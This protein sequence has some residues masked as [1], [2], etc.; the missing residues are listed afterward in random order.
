M[1]E[2]ALLK[3]SGRDLTP[4]VLANLPGSFPTLGQS[5]STALLTVKA[6]HI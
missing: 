6:F 3:K 2:M 1:M 5:A 4:K